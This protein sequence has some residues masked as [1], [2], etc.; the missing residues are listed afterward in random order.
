[1]TDKKKPTDAQS[2]RQGARARSGRY[3]IMNP[4]GLCGK[5]LGDSLGYMSN[6]YAEG[7]DT[8]GRGGWMCP[9]CCNKIDCLPDAEALR[10]LK[11]SP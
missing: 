2:A 1:M 5:G 8:T 6:F 3:R 9:D 10:L 11:E 4:C 7:K